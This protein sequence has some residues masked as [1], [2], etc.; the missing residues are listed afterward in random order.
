[1]ERAPT[2]LHA[3]LQTKKSRGCLRRDQGAGRAR[4]ERVDPRPTC[5]LRQLGTGRRHPHT[6]GRAALR[7][8][9]SDDVTVESL[10]LNRNFRESLVVIRD[11]NMRCA[12]TLSN[13]I[14]SRQDRA[15]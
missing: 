12:L 6:R 2:A 8:T 3:G 13:T 1:M 15:I 5:R 10:R 14:H 4:A 11:E 9:R 7:F